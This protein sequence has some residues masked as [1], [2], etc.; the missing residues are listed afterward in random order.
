MGQTGK[1]ILGISLLLF[2]ATLLTGQVSQKPFPTVDGPNT[3]T[4]LNNFTGGLQSNNIDAADVSSTQALTNKTLTSPTVTNPSTTGTDSGTETLSNKN[5]PTFTFGIGISN[6][7]NAA[8]VGHN[9]RFGT[10]DDIAWRNSGNTAN[11]AL[12]HTSADELQWGSTSGGGFRPG[13]TVFANLGTPA[14]GVLVYCS[15][16]TIANPCAGAGNGAIAKRL[17]GVWVCN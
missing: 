4:A 15:D 2:A 12:N 1:S 8:G 9:I 14:N 16:C 6:S 7:A 13:S 17:N 11:I 10:F 3:W 5:L